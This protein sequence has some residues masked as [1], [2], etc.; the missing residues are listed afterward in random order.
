MWSGRIKLD[1]WVRTKDYP[2][3]VTDK[4]VAEQKLAA[5]VKELE[6]EDAGISVSRV[7]RDALLRPLSDH[8]AA[9][10]A[11]LKGKGRAVRTI[12]SYRNLLR[13]TFERCGWKTFKDVSALSFA[14]W[15]ASSTLKPHSLNDALGVVLTLFNWMERNGV[16][17]GNP[18]RRIQ[19]VTDT[20]VGCY[21][22]ALSA[23][24]ITR[25][26]AAAPR[27]RAWVYL[28]ILYTGLRRHELN[29]LTWGHLHLEGEHPFI[30]LPA[31]ITKN[32]KVGTQPLRAEVVS[33]LRVQA[34]IAGRRALTGLSPTKYSRGPGDPSRRLG[35]VCGADRWA[36]GGL[37]GS[38]ADDSAIEPLPFEWV[39]RGKV[40]TPAK[41][42]VDLDAAGVPAM[43]ERGRI[44][45]VHALRGTFCTMLSVA[46]VSPRTAMALMRHSDLKLTMRHYTDEAQLP[47]SADVQ[48]L[49]SFNV[50]AVAIPSDRNAQTDSQIH[51]Q[52]AVAGSVVES[53]PVATSLNLANRQDAENVSFSPA[54]SSP[55]ITGANPE[56]VGAAR[57]EL[58][59]GE[60]QR[61]ERQDVIQQ[62]PTVTHKC[63]HM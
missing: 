22:R 2:L 56:M 31:N 17:V 25:V 18:L 48:R 9:F 29:Q 45:D 28:T 55:D 47:M 1:G 46:G 24:E 41:L 5:L 4:R 58:N 20:N 15:R 6:R 62:H 50:K 51:S 39:F 23:D 14:E 36:D 19:K 37:S 60:S 8:V 42:R 7:H 49:P 40:P 61:A 59:E 16:I 63:P 30:E 13:I 33:A 12:K 3:G 11:D 21:R 10:L 57:F 32:R 43:D 38:A 44:V 54:E 53:L 35:D 27:S 52:T 26:I 34:L